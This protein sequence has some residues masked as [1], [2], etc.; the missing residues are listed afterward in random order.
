MWTT[1]IFKSPNFFLK[2]KT[3]FVWML[4]HI[5]SKHVKKGPIFSL[6][7]SHIQ[8]NHSIPVGSS[9]SNKKISK[10]KLW[11][12]WLWLKIIYFNDVHNISWN[13]FKGRNT[14]SSIAINYPQYW[15]QCWKLSKYCECQP[16][17]K[18]ATWCESHG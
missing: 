8:Q 7:I 18:I 2:I 3:S 5:L 1:Y 16:V 17:L 14:P 11:F 10:L 13:G 15:T 12:V 9:V 6:T 4:F